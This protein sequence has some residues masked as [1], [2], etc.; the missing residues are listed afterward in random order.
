MLGT[1][2]AYGYRSYFSQSRFDAAAAGHHRRHVDADQDRP[3]HRRRSAI[4]KASPGPPRP[5]PARSRWSRKQEEPVALKEL[6]DPSRSARRCFRRRSLRSSR[7]PGR[8]NGTPAAQEGR[9]RVTIRPDG[10]R[11]ER[12]ARSRRIAASDAVTRPGS[13][14]AADDATCAPGQRPRR[15]R[16]NG[17]PISLDPQAERAGTAAPARQPDAADRAGPRAR[18]RRQSVGAWISWCS[19]PRRRARP[20]R[21]PRSAACRP[22]S[23]ASSASR[24]PI[25]RRA[26]LGSKGVFYRT[27]VGPFASV[28]EASQFCASY[29]AAGG[30]CVVRATDCGSRSEVSYRRSQR[31]TMRTSK[32]KTTTIY[33]SSAPLNPK[34]A[35]NLPRVRELRVRALVGRRWRHALSSPALPGTMLDGGGARLPARGRAVGPHRLQAQ[36]RDPG[37][38]APV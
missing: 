7:P 16:R 5:T 27:M 9:A 30:Q 29:K 35:L 10:S 24:Q 17:G 18:R 23:R 4:G 36:Y 2:G 33:D 15:R 11:R 14:A 21:K 26:D 32:S 13:D 37:A 34:F 25:I 38:S 1:A 19:S 6:A 12:Q 3:R 31:V 20:R 28:H 8:R 22:S